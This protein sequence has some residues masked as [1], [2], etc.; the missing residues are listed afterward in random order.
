MGVYSIMH[1]SSKI[2][3]EDSSE[4]RK[5]LQC[6]FDHPFELVHALN[7]PSDPQLSLIRHSILPYLF[8]LHNQS[9]QNQCLVVY[10][11]ELDAE[12]LLR[13]AG[14]EEGLEVEVLE[15]DHKSKV[16]HS[17]LKSQQ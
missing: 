8:A 16:M 13:M 11:Y 2:V 17:R 6:Y 7:S 9:E 14:E 10:K 3:A 5:E 4:L 15:Y 12:E 1:L